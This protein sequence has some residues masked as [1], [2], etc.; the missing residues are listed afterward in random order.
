M[1]IACPAGCPGAGTNSVPPVTGH[2][3]DLVLS[4]TR[5]AHQLVVTYLPASR[6]WTMQLITAALFLAIAAVA[7]GAA[8]WLLHRRTT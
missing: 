6:F 5:S 1:R 4:V 3:G 2:L 7:L 8:V